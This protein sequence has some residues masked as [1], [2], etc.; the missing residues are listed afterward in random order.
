VND[1]TAKEQRVHRTALHFLR[2]RVDAW[3]R[4][5]SES[6]AV[7]VGQHPEGRAARFAEIPM[8]ERL[9]GQWLS[10]RGPGVLPLRPPSYRS[11]VLRCQGDYSHRAARATTSSP[12]R[13]RPRW[14]SRC[15]STTW[16]PKLREV[17]SRP[18]RWGRTRKQAV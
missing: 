16:V 6:D 1:L 4:A 11:Q 9:A 3:G 18:S 17:S 10:A 12:R 7:R 5:P 15:S 8:N 14:T 13:S 2:Q